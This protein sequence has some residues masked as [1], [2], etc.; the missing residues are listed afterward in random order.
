MGYCHHERQLGQVH[1]AQKIVDKNIQGKVS[2]EMK[3][4]NDSVI[5][6]PKEILK[7]IFNRLIDV[8]VQHMNPDMDNLNAPVYYSEVMTKEPLI[9]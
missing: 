6:A 3:L 2:N 4:R 7:K 8:F 5:F 9:D 1:L